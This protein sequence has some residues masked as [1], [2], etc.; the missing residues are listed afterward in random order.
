MNKLKKIALEKTKI[1]EQINEL[2]C[3]IEALQKT[4]NKND[5][6]ELTK[7]KFK[8]ER[9]L[10]KLCKKEKDVKNEKY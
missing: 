1:C 5:I 9:K 8:L 6:I 3:K 2:L 10:T 4:E 7:E